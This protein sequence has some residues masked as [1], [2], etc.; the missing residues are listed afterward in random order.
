MAGFRVA[1]DLM[2]SQ[3]MRPVGLRASRELRVACSVRSSKQ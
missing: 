2:P 1:T 3:R